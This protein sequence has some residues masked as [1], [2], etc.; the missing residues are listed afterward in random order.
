MDTARPKSGSAARPGTLTPTRLALTVLLLAGAGCVRDKP[1]ITPGLTRADGWTS[2]PVASP[3]GS[4]TTFHVRTEVIPLGALPYDG[5]VLPLVSPGGRYLAVQDGAPPTWSTLL[6]EFAATPPTATRLGVYDMAARPPARVELPEP[7]PRGL[8][9]GRACD[10]RGFL[11]EA[12]RDDG[13][14][15]IGRVGWLGGGVE[16]L[17]QGTAVNAHAALT[18]DGDA[19]FTRRSPAGDRAALVLRSADGHEAELSDP[20]GSYAMPLV[21]GDPRTAHALV[22]SPQG[23]ELETLRIVEDPP[24]GG[25]RVLVPA[26]A[27]SRLASRGDAALAYQVAAPAQLPWPGDTLRDPR[28]PVVLY[29]PRIGRMAVFD[30]ASGSFVALAPGSIAAAHWPRAG[31]E[32]FFCT[33]PQGLVFTPTPTPEERGSLRPR[34]PDARVLASPYVPRLTGD[35]QR[36]LLLFGPDPQDRSR[37]QLF[38]MRLDGGAP[39]Q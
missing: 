6:A 24:G 34:P 5:Q 15:W 2:G 16:W 32:G 11:V 21:A 1:R 19:L 23:L 35:P 12:P 30:E 13:S 20:A 9:L 29:H 14:R 39:P 22:F 36:P 7:L 37:L 27:R 3:A 10:D 25:R 17:V 4:T 38:Q 31:R 33:A 18:R 26:G 28:A 8:V